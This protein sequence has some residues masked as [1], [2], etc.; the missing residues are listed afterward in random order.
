[1]VAALADSAHGCRDR[2]LLLIGFAAA[3]RRSDLVAPA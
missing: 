2:A 3:V 1:M